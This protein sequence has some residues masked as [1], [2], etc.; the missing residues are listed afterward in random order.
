MKSIVLTGGGTAGHVT[1]NIA[2]IEP[3]K[4]HGWEIA[5]IGSDTGVE[6]QM[7]EALNIQFYA[8]S[9]GKLRRYL[10]WQNCIDPFKVLIGIV[11]SYL[12]LKKIKPDV[13]F[14]KGGFVAL[15]VVIGAYLHRIPVIAHESDISPGLA[16]R[17]SFPFVDKICVTFEAAKAH[18]KQKNK[19]EVTGTPIRPFLFEGDREKGL[20]LCGFHAKKP[21]LLVVG[22]SLGADSLNQAVR[23]GL[24]QFT[25]QYQVIHLCG[26]GKCDMAYSNHPDYYQLEYASGELPDLLAAADVVVSRSGAN[27]LYELL[28]LAKP[29]VLVPLSQKVSRGDQIQNAKFFQS[30]GISTVIDAELLSSALLLSSVNNVFERRVELIAKIQALKIGSATDKMIQLIEALIVKGKVCT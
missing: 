13:V 1:P 25:E 26:K 16:N 7:I 9:S 19:V 2:L 5:Y 8:V 29:H 4:Q 12:L 18:F 15:P 27:A 24:N 22:G 30:Q 20:T 21:V 6:R 23:Q 3:L 10:S 14:S 11:Q 28:A 17:L